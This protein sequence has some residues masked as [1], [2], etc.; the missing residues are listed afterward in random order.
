MTGDEL[1]LKGIRVA[2]FSWFGAGPIFT[3]A[4][5]HYGA[6][7]IRIESQIRPDGLRLTQPMPKD[8]PPG[9]N[10]SG[11]YNN[12]NAGKLSFS[13]NMASQQGRELALRLIAK[14][15]IVAENF[16]PGT[17]EKWGLTY[18]R[19]LQVKPD[20]IMVREPM[21]G[22]SGPHR[23]F[24]GFGAVITPLAGISYLSG[25]PH[26]PPVG[27]GT[28]YTDYVINPGHALVATLAALRY[29]NRTGKGQLIE[30]AQFE[31][32]VNVISVAL[33]DCAA[34]GRVQER[35]GNRLPYACPHGAYRCQGDDRWV[36]IAVFS[37]EEWEAFCR[38]V[39]EE[40][41]RDQRFATLLGRKAHED[42]LDRLIESWTSQREAEEVMEQ[43]QAAGVPAGVVQSAADTLD[44]DPHLKARGY[45]HY[46]EHPEAGRT[47]YDGP[48]F[49]LSETP[50][51]PRGPAPLL[52]QHTEYVCKQVLG[53]SDDEIAD[54]VAEGVL[55]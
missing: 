46:L 31:S 39:D 37:D 3:M 2:D 41:V 22:L 21:Q 19:I 43:L 54:L 33:L 7:V 12:F 36:A 16:T 32:S 20:I 44:R 17:F 48:G 40:W 26:R 30:V 11:Y 9:I 10:L 55:Q 35:Q 53:L 24:A 6:E 18:E 42:E 34:N 45:Y 15:D 13:L 50:G 4:L 23:D 29:R 5:A 25:F 14:S 27:L 28:N 1:P 52:G 38:V 47:A 51:G 8:R 49:R